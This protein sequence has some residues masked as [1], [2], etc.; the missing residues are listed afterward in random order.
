MRINSPF[1]ISRRNDFTVYSGSQR[2][3]IAKVRF[4]AHSGP[5]T[6]GYL[7]LK[8]KKEFKLKVRLR[9]RTIDVWSFTFASNRPFVKGQRNLCLEYGFDYTSK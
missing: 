3:S 6:Y 8:R 9:S 7:R 4:G 1:N 5:T 2:P